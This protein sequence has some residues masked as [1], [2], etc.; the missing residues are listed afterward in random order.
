[1]KG[2][3]DKVEKP[4]E[5]EVEKTTTEEHVPG[6]GVKTKPEDDE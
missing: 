5:K 1:M 2:K 6:G 3:K 4:K